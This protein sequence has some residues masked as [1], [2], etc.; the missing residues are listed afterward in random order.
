MLRRRSW[1]R[2]NRNE[3][4]SL[5]MQERWRAREKVN[6]KS[7]K[8]STVIDGWRLMQSHIKYLLDGQTRKKKNTK[9][10]SSSLDGS[11]QTI[12][13]AKH[14]EL[15]CFSVPF[16]LRNWHLQT[17]QK[18]TASTQHCALCHPPSCHRRHGHVII[19]V[20]T[21]FRTYKKENAKHRNS[22]TW[23]INA[24]TTG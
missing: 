3:K 17:H 11:W 1:W 7:L 15:H 2:R 13:P 5:T 20:S 14:L 22:M 4:N 16:W 24:K 8:W 10:S 9:R 23:K 19:R 18:W 6:G 21:T 12:L